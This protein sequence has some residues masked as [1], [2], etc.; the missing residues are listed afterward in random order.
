MRAVTAVLQGL[1]DVV[2]EA[3]AIVTNGNGNLPIVLPP[4][5][6][7]Y[8]YPEIVEIITGGHQGSLRSDGSTEVEIAAIT[9]CCN[10]VGYGRL[11]CRTR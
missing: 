10:E 8:G 1:A 9:S 6:K 4:M 2:P 5:E 11:T 7:V 3:N